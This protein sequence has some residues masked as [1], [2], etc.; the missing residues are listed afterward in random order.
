VGVS[1]FKL[2]SVPFHLFVFCSILLMRLTDTDNV[3]LRH[4]NLLIINASNKRAQLP[5]LEL[6]INTCQQVIYITSEPIYH[7]Q[8]DMLQLLIISNA[9]SQCIFCLRQYKY[10][11]KLD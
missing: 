8:Y 6:S 11:Q 3:F 10:S 2:N 4:V 7:L 9:S 1:I 5:D